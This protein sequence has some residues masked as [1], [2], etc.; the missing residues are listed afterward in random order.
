MRTA[1]RALWPGQWTRNGGYRHYVY[2]GWE[3]TEWKKG[4]AFAYVIDE[5][6]GITGGA[7]NKQGRV[8][9]N[10]APMPFCDR[11]KRQ[12]FF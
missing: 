6:D 7:Y 3:K 11:P 10:H 1:G 12:C 2:E 8:T 9:E 4:E 5:A